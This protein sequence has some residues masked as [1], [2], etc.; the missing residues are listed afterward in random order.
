MRVLVRKTLGVI[1][2]HYAC[3]GYQI[4]HLFYCNKINLAKIL[5]LKTLISKKQ[6]LNR[7]FTSALLP[8]T[9]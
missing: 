9:T 5:A 4:N 7:N 6:G 2:G 8:G 3:D 1:F